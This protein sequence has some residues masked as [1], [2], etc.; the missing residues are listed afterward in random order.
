MKTGFR[1]DADLLDEAQC[2]TFANASS[3]SPSALL[4]GSHPRRIWRG[5]ELMERLNHSRPGPKDDSLET[6]TAR[7]EAPA[8]RFL[9]EA[10]RRS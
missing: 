5:G 2:P 7:L 1:R 6:A 9:I 3:N 8:G 10:S 4:R